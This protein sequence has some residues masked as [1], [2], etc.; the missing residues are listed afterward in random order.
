M[1]KNRPASNPDRR[2]QIRGTFENMPPTASMHEIKKAFLAI[3]A[4]ARTQARLEK[5]TNKRHIKTHTMFTILNHY[6]AGQI[7][8]LKPDEIR[9]IESLFMNKIIISQ[10]S[11]DKFYEWLNQ[12]TFPASTRQPVAT[13]AE[14]HSDHPEN[15]AAMLGRAAVAQ[16][17]GPPKNEKPKGWLA[18]IFGV[19]QTKQ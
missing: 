3:P 10:Y 9:M 15:Y 1:G 13:Q 2:A 7:R 17:E 6:M 19:K 14:P 16:I 8:P 11:V 12:T 18:R 5:W 4:K